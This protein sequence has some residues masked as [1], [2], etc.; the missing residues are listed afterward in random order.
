MNKWLLSGAALLA[1]TT[2]ST[3]SAS[4]SHRFGNFEVI[5]IRDTATAMPPA[6]FPALPPAEFHRLAGPGN[7]PASV[8]VFVLKRAGEVTL[9]DTGNGGSRGQLGAELKKL[10][11]APENVSTVLLTH[12]HGDHIGGLLN[13]EGR[14]AYPAAAVLVAAPELGY[15]RSTS[16]PGG[17]SVRKML[18]AYGNRVKTFRFGDEVRPGIRALDAAG[19]TPGHTVFDV[20]ELLIVGDLLH[21]A[22]IQFARPEICAAYDLNQAAAVRSRKKICDLAADSGKPIAGMH[23]P[24]PGIGRVERRS[25]GYTFIPER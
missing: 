25:A 11:I 6:L 14:A 5:A 20:G 21:A 18:T 9:V 23:I 17:E 22:D 19:H 1:G 16:G 7:A 3:V 4:E 10:G 15:W 13:P 12:M 8:N 24:F 2:L